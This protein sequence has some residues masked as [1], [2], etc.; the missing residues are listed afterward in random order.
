MWL[1]TSHHE[2]LGGVF[3]NPAWKLDIFI[4][5][6]DHFFFKNCNDTF[7]EDE[8]GDTS[9]FLSLLPFSAYFIYNRFN[10]TSS[11]L[12]SRGSLKKSPLKRLVY[13]SDSRREKFSV[14]PWFTTTSNSSP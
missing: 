12:C 10:P 8:V 13:N 6:S 2:T 7:K 11:P 4:I 3:R 1:A 14:V 5:R 9:S